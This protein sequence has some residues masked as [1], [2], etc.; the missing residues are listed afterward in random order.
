MP[1]WKKP[2]K[3]G[4]GPEAK[5]QGKGPEAKAQGKVPE[6]P[7]RVPQATARHVCCC[8]LLPPL[9]LLLLVQTSLSF[10]CFCRCFFWPPLLLL[11]L[12]SVAPLALK[13]WHTRADCHDPSQGFH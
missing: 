4:K 1:P 7:A 11:S 2:W 9:L 5:A 10:C 8:L 3:K 12:A 6:A 13:C